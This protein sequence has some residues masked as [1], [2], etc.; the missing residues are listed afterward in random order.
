MIDQEMIGR[1]N[2]NHL[3]TSLKSILEYFNDLFS[4]FQV[5]TKYYDQTN[6][7][8]FCPIAQTPKN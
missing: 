5:F 8:I 7:V 6:I 1:N 4:S 3:Y 2:F